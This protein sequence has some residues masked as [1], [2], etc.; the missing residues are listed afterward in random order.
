MVRYSGSYTLCML[1]LRVSEFTNTSSSICTVR[2]FC[3][4]LIGELFEMRLTLLLLYVTSGPGTLTIYSSVS[5]SLSLFVSYQRRIYCLVH[6]DLR[7][8][9]S[10]ER[11]YCSPDCNPGAVYSSRPQRPSVRPLPTPALDPHSPPF[12]FN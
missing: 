4:D 2:A 3:H 12:M 8:P 10:G 9:A 1:Q 6:S 7:C 5:L 11:L